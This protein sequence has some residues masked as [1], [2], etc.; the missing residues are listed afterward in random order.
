MNSITHLNHRLVKFTVNLTLLKIILSAQNSGSFSFSCDSLW[1]EPSC[2]FDSEPYGAE[3]QGESGCCT[4]ST[5]HVEG[6]PLLEEVLGVAPVHH[7]A[8]E[9]VARGAHGHGSVMR[10]VGVRVVAVRVHEQD[11]RIEV[12][13]QG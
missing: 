6:S 11:G 9:G 13:Q 7:P 3:V 8:V 10:R 4:S 5:H 2:E 1:H 12:R